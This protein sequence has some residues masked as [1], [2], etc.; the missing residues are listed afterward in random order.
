MCN[1]SMALGAGLCS[2]SLFLFLND[3]RLNFVDS[4]SRDA[5][6]PGPFLEGGGGGNCGFDVTLVAL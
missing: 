6:R 2:R 1:D 3:E 5:E 4:L